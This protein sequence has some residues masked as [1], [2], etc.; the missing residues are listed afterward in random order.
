MARGDVWGQQKGFNPLFKKNKI[1]IVL[2]ILLQP[3]INM[4]FHTQINSEVEHPGQA[5]SQPA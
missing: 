2:P 5:N 1:V 3:E 4:M